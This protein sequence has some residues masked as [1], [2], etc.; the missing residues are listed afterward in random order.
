MIEQITVNAAAE[1]LASSSV[2]SYGIPVAIGGLA[3][4]FFA[5]SYY[6]HRK[7]K[8]KNIIQPNKPVNSSGLHSLS[9]SGWLLVKDGASLAQHLGV[10]PK[11]KL[12]L[13]QSCLDQHTSGW[14][15]QTL[16]RYVEF[17]QLLP[18]SEAHHHANPGGLA[19]HTIEVALL[20]LRRRRGQLLPKGATQEERT[21]EQHRWTVAVLLCALFHDAG[22]VVTDVRVHGL[23]HD[24]RELE[25][26]PMGGSMK[27]IGIERYRV[28]FKEHQYSDHK[29]LG[30]FLLSLLCPKEMLAWLGSNQGLMHGMNAYLS[31]AQSG[32]LNYQSIRDIVSKA[33]QSSV[34]IDLGYGA[35][36][37]F[38][39]ART[40]PL[41]DVVMEAMHQLFKHNLL[42]VNQPGAAGYVKDGEIFLVS[43]I[44]A[45]TV[46]DYIK[47]HHQSFEVSL[48]NDNER[49][50]SMWQDYGQLIPNPLGKAMWRAEFSDGE[51]FKTELTVLRFPLEVVFGANMSLWPES[52][53]GT[54]RINDA[55]ANS[56]LTNDP[57]VASATTYKS[58][59]ISHNP[60]VASS[61]LDQSEEF[62]ELSAFDE[63]LSPTQISETVDE[64]KD[65]QNKTA[66]STPSTTKKVSMP[67]SRVSKVAS[68]HKGKSAST[69]TQANISPTP[70]VQADDDPFADMMEAIPTASAQDS[71]GES[72]SAQVEEEYLPEQM[73]AKSEFERSLSTPEEV[74]NVPVS[75]AVPNLLTGGNEP[76][77]LTMSFITWLK[78][79]LANGEITYNVSRAPVQF[80]AEG[81]GLVSPSIFEKF[82]AQVGLSDWREIQKSLIESDLIVRQPNGNKLFK[83]LVQTPNNQSD[84]VNTKRPVLSMILLANPQLYVH[85][86]PDAN[87]YLTLNTNSLLT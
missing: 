43:K 74:L 82:K 29:S 33:D 52:F 6:E 25:W 87:R 39:A 13:S 15:E 5:L 63:P 65:H 22:K 46:R 62:V 56:V 85:P 10:H 24:G 40:R 83:Y 51:K 64:V 61:T 17:V 44:I 71:V 12:I 14:L 30:A 21:S 73:S 59:Q 50:F 16:F 1:F 38:S 60:K 81:M 42:K 28:F 36:P 7:S 45:D 49:L 86:V 80:V 19:R 77:E 68:G 72:V 8:S 69:A 58:T 3:S 57:S 34:K 66:V 84:E 54:I 70:I 4:I 79:G 53:T 9:H 47:K 41:I 32:D 75:L 26:S 78:R 23:T 18:A 35:Q 55:S 20:S 67:T 11:I 27:A 76:N 48:P 37:Q 31:D 2:G